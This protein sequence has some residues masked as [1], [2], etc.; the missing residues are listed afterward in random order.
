M[1]NLYLLIKLL[2]PWLFFHENLIK[3][4]KQNHWAAK[5][6]LTK[7]LNTYPIICSLLCSS[8]ASI[9]SVITNNH[10][11]PNTLTPTYILRGMISWPLHI[12]APSLFTLYLYFKVGPTLRSS[13]LDSLKLHLHLNPCTNTVNCE[14]D[15]FLKYP[16]VFSKEKDKI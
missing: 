5:L 1:L 11:N 4:L 16:S 14:K 8:V 6:M 7:Q 13:T 9:K 12:Y 2:Q 10:S 15:T 3:L